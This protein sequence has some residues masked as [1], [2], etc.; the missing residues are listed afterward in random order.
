MTLSEVVALDT[1]LFLLINLGMANKLF[2]IVMPAIT[3]HGLALLMPYLL[4]M[5]WKGPKTGGVPY[6]KSVLWTILIA[7]ASAIMAEGI[8][9]AIRYGSARIRPCHVLQGIRLLVICPNSFSMP[10]GHALR[11]FAPAIPLSHLTHKYIQPMWRLYPLIL[12]I[13]V[14]FSRVY[15][16]VHYPSDIVAGAL[17]GAA[18]GAVISAF[19]ERSISSEISR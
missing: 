3:E 12:A 4:Y 14:A 18:V 15:V 17:L 9:L 11:S 1:K 19:Y 16:G 10:S 8:G 7:L 5:L 2:D 6:F 13:L